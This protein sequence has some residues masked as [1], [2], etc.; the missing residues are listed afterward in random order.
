M[1]LYFT[2]NLYMAKPFLQTH[3][4]TFASLLDGCGSIKR[5]VQL[6]KEYGH[7]SI[8]ITDHGNMSNTYNMFSEARKQGIKAVL[9]CEYYLKGDTFDVEE[10]V[11]EEMSDD[12]ID[13]SEETEASE[14]EN[15]EKVEEKKKIKRINYHQ[16]VLVKDADGWKNA[17]KLN[18]Y[19]FLK[20]DHVDYDDCKGDFYRKP[21]IA[22]EFLFEAHKG[23]ITTSTCMASEINRLITDDKLDLAAQ[24]IEE[25]KRIF[26]TD[27]YLELQINEINTDKISQKK[28]NNQLIEFSK[29]FNI[30]TILTGDVHY[31]DKGDAILQD[32]SIA[33]SRKGTIYDD[34]AFKLHARNLYFHD[35]EDYYRLNKELGYDYSEQFIDECLDNTLEISDKCNFIF[36]TSKKYPKF[37]STQDESKKKLIQLCKENI[38]IYFEKKNFSDELQ[39]KYVERLKYELSIINKNEYADYF[40]VVWDI[41]QFC[42]R[43]DIWTG[44]GRGSV[45]SSLV[46]FLLGISGLDPVRYDLYFERFV[47]PEALSTPDIDLDFD[48]ERRDEVIEYIKQKWG[49]DRVLRIGNYNTFHVR[50]T[51]R[52]LVR[53]TKRSSDDIHFICSNDGANIP[54][55]LTDET[56]DAWF[57]Q[58]AT[59]IDSTA[60]R[61]TQWYNENSD[62]ISWF[63]KMYGEMRHLSQ[64]AAGILITP[65]PVWFYI[66]INRTGKTIVTGFPESSVHKDLSDLGLLKLDILG[67]ETISQIRKTVELIRQTRGID[68][69]EQ[70]ID[71]DLD[72][73]ELYTEFSKGDNLGIFQFEGHGISQTVKNA[74]PKTFEEVAAINSLHR[75][76]ALIS[77]GTDKFI[78]VSSGKEPIELVH[79]KYDAIV[80]PTNG[81]IA[82]QEQVTRIIHECANIPLGTCE[83]IRKGTSTTIAKFQKYTDIFEN[84]FVP[85]CVENGIPEETAQYIKEII[86]KNGAYSFNASHSYAYGF[87]ALQTLYLKLYYPIEFYCTIL[88][89]GASE[90]VYAQY[91]SDAIKR[92]IK[93]YEPSVL[94][95]EYNFSPYLDG[96]IVGLKIMKGFGPKAAAELFSCD[97]KWE[98]L[99]DFLFEKWSKLNKSAIEGLVLTGSLREL[100]PHTKIAHELCVHHIENK[101]NIDKL[102]RKKEVKYSRQMF[103]DKYEFLKKSLIPDYT[104]KEM[105][106]QWKDITDFRNPFNNPFIKYLEMLKQYGVVPCTTW[107]SKMPFV[108]GLVDEIKEDF[109]KNNK[110]FLRITLTDG[111]GT[112]KVK[113]WS[114][115]FHTYPELKTLSSGNI[116]V[117]DLDKDMFGYTFAKNGRFSIIQ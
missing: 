9:G 70:I 32:I 114:N 84:E 68:I 46:A 74:A 2:L 19:S 77:G 93:V 7:E 11:D 21:R 34:N 107:D 71:L 23:L 5:Y 31:A 81:V 76:A 106:A 75:P 83:L 94:H 90:G 35:R 40:L 115:Q 30:K 104:Q 48:S 6:A 20:N 58:F 33:L 66:P 82:F 3:L 27:F 85:K 102:N 79:P 100:E 24:L 22:K 96:L 64:H 54:E 57:L 28:I 39:K 50:G 37:F 45:G 105:D 47:N 62:L 72:N 91:I 42:K 1:L 56:I 108:Y 80:A 112:I 73:K 116:V 110:L 25:Y 109:T 43:E 95:S 10:L 117:M 92:N 65:E 99:G 4:H 113:V 103:E 98:T 17:C 38:K 26:G 67:L 87:I 36:D 63:K 49:N 12:V 18:Y 13:D 29:A 101:A 89:S 69:K 52:D 51:L 61:L 14:E 86:I 78:K 59:G 16:I 111:F 41:M 15:I 8:A 55:D 60:K 97:R 53:A 44:I 88:S